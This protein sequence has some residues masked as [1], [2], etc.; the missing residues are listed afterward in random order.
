VRAKAAEE[1]GGG[2]IPVPPKYRSADFL[3]QDF[4]RLRGGLDVPKERFVSF[5]HCSPDADGSLVVTWAGY[6][7]LALATAIG[8]TYQTR[9][10][11]EG[12]PAER[13]TPLLAGLQELLP[14]LIQW[15]NDYDAA[16]GGGMGDYFADL[17]REEARELGLTEAA[18]AAWQPPAK[19]RKARGW[20][21][22]TPSA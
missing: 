15:H 19:P 9:K 10:D 8:T 7:H 18:L 6:D 1:D 4:S 5:P 16:I 17:V 3:S 13:L 20:K 22:R 11:E 2:D 14:W 12:W 21:T